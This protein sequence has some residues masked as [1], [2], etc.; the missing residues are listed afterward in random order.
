M[1]DAHVYSVPLD[2]H[3]ETPLVRDEGAV[4]AALHRHPE[5]PDALAL[6]LPEAIAESMDRAGIDRSVLVSLPWTSLDLCR[7]NNDHVLAAAAGSDRFLAVC[8]VQALDSGWRTEVDRAREAGAVGIKINTGWQGGALDSSTTHDLARYVA[9][10]GL[11]L[12]THVDHAFRAS[13]TGPSGLYGLASA[14]PGTRIVAAHLGGL[15]GLYTHHP[16]VAEALAN[17][18]FDTAVS[19]TLEMVRYYAQA[20]LGDRLLFGS[21]FPFNHSHSQAQVMAGLKALDL[22]QTA[23]D[24]I[25]ENN[26]LGLVER[27]RGRS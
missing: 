12:M 7:R 6:S 8:S 13:D 10:S 21:D 24:G 4:L 11:F 19:S 23:L 2:L 17:V 16:P 22:P 27:Q 1:I 18:W 9:E 25:M 3:A 14:C 20:G 26:F 15:L 5:G